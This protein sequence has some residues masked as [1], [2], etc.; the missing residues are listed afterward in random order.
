MSLTELE[1]QQHLTLSTE[2]S[3]ETKKIVTMPSSVARELV[4]V[5]SHAIHYYAMIEQMAKH[6]KKITP[7]SFGIAPATATFLRNEKCA[8]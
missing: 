1:L 8:H 6:T 7:E 3:I 4:F 5:G 2:V